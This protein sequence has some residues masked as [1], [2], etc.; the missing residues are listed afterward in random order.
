M[1][2]GL[3]VLLAGV[4]SLFFMFNTGQL[5]AEKTKL[6]N[7]ADAVAYSAGVMHARALNFNSYTNRAM[8]ANEVLMAQMVS[9]IS[10]AEYAAQHSGNAPQLGCYTVYNIPVGLF[11]LKYAPLCYLLANG[12]ASINGTKTYVVGAAKAVALLGEAAKLNLMAAQSTMFASLVAG[13]PDLLQQV[14]DANYANDGTV[15]VDDIPLT[16]D[17]LRFE[18][19][20]G[21]LFF[22]L[23]TGNDRT[24]F[25]E[26]EVRAANLDD[27]VR[28]R[29]WSDSTFGLGCF[30]QPQGN[31]N[32]TGST[33]LSGF[34][35]WR[36]RDRATLTVRSWHISLFSAGC[37]TDWSRTM[38][39]TNVRANSSGSD[40][41]YSGVPVYYD[42][43]EKARAYNPTHTDEKKRDPRL[44]FAIR[45]TRSN[46]EA[47]TSTGKSQIKPAGQLNRFQGNEAKN[48]M[49]AVAT[50]EVFFERPFDEPRADGKTEL[51]SLF[52]PFWQ[53][54]LIANSDA[55]V[56]AAIALQATP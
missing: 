22:K 43:H 50:S 33:T 15:S 27:F 52:N 45:L 19:V 40:V 18:G 47:R 39:N 48:V 44:K 30:F 42:L 11:L 37:K 41:A 12:Y 31:A 26:V 55:D 14:A 34:T 46:T 38:G 36:A 10:W 5:T 17:L 49:A 53:V 3:F 2:Y 21:Q 8:I 20:P 7:T 9:T 25:K 1:V 28:D 51:A 24:R 6:V 16:D 13:R 56:A 29:S 54:H 35:E 23:Y 4:G 32:R